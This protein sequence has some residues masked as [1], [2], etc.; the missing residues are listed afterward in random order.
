MIDEQTIL[1]KIF[2]ASKK[3][4]CEAYIVGGFPRDILLGKDAKDIDI[5]VFG[6][7]KEVARILKNE[8]SANSIEIERYKIV[9]LFLK[10]RIIDVEAPKGKNI[11]SDLKKRDFTINTLVIP[12]EKCLD[13]KANIMD[14]LGTAKDDIYH[15]FLRTPT[16]PA[17][18]IE[19]D[20]CR[21]VRI[22]RFIS[23]GFTAEEELVRE[24]KKKVKM[25]SSIPRERIGFELRKLFLSKKPSIGLLFLREIGFFEV[26]FPKISPALY[27]DQKSPYHF[28]G[29]FEH[30]ARVVDLTPPDIV[31][32]LAAFFHDIGK[33]YAEKTLPDG[34]VVYWG[35]EI[36]SAE[37]CNDFLNT[38]KFPKEER[39]KAVFVV[40]N[41]M[42]YYN[43]SW[44]DS[45]VRRLMKKIYPH[46]DLVLKFVYYDIKAMRDPEPKLKSLEELKERI[47]KEILKLGKA[48]I[49]SPL[50]GYELQRIF[51]L[52]PGKLIG[53]LKS[54]IENAIIEGKIKPTK[55]DAIRFVKEILEKKKE[56][57]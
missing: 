45:A 50:D 2:D 13:P 4:N 17:K 8:L 43:S 46:T 40:R 37:I 16:A 56:S 54:A 41:H 3:F 7:Y 20:P 53:E 32:R 36:I 57:S 5:V 27:K 39:E 1:R 6:D 35:H 19:E 14:P 38:F 49:R 31:L 24:A 47:E 48:D 30:C 29:V 9:R 28:E 34:R 23:E 51:G 21:I 15:R 44:S 11:I 10:D 42:I 25:L 55:E 12:V 22:A 26:V 18:T 33:A 52:K